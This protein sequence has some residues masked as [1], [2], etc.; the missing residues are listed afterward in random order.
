MKPVAVAVALA[1]VAGVAACGKA[2]AT[3]YTKAATSACL[4]KAGFTPRPV[5]SAVDF[6]A[7]SATGGAFRVD[8]TD[9]QV[10]ISFGATEADADNIDDAYHRFRSANVGIE[11]VLRRDQ[12]A[13]MLWHVHPS[14]ADLATVGNCLQS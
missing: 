6:V 11:D 13:V 3:L 14:D 7:N 4:E 9:N 8:L 12:N 5:E 10:T 1:L 2:G